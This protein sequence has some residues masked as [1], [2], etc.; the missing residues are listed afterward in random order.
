VHLQYVCALSANAEAAGVAK[1]YAAGMDDFY[2]KPVKIPD[3]IKHLEGKF[4][5]LYLGES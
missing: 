1:A 5:S 3:L 2:A 4:L